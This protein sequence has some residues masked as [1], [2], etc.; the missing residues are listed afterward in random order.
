MIDTSQSYSPS[1]CHSSMTQ[2]DSKEL[3][4]FYDDCEHDDYMTAEDYDRRQYERD[5]WNESR[6]DRQYY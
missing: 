5:G 3:Y 2:T 1:K 6:Y 4:T